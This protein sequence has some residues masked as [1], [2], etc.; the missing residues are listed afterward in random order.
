TSAFP[1]LADHRVFGEVVAPAGCYLA[2]M[3]NGARRLGHTACR[4]ED[5]FF[6]APLVLTDGGERTLQSVLDPDGGFRIISFGPKESPE[7]MTD[8]VRGRMTT[9]GGEDAGA[10]LLDVARA[11]CQEHIDTEVLADG[12][13][14]IEFGPSFR[15]I[16]DLW[17]GRREALARLRLP[18]VV[19]S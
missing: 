17:L 3:L 12:I 9:S 14:G 13:E 18:A 15:W 16:E 4:L 7:E 10:A 1:Y 8:H 6:V 2:M 19:A 5:V 11:R